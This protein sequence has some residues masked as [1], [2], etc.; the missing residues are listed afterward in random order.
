M[1]RNEHVHCNKDLQDLGFPSGRILEALRNKSR[2]SRKRQ[3]SCDK[4]TWML[5][6][7]RPKLT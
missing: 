7:F 5:S 6:C 3:Q 2:N 4:G 1:K